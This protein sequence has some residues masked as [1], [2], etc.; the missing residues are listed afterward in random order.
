MCDG[1]KGCKGI[2]DARA[3]VSGA[4]GA[5]TLRYKGTWG[6]RAQGAR[7]VRVLGMSGQVQGV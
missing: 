4:R 7:H 6:E 2:R 1:C 3:G 5:Q